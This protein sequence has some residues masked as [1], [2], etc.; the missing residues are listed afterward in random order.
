MLFIKKLSYSTDLKYAGINFY[1]YPNGGISKGRR[2]LL[3]V[4]AFIQ[5]EGKIY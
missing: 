2:E 4:K 1:Y 5:S 3:T